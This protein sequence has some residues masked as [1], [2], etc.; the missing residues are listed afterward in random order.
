MG[1]L[2]YFYSINY[3]AFEHRLVLISYFTSAWNTIVYEITL[4]EIAFFSKVVLTFAVELI[5]KELPDEKI[6]I[7]KLNPSLATL[8]TLNPTT[9]VN[10][11]IL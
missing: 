4:I 7:L 9:F 8:F 2:S 6:P 10:M 11:L 1:S 3:F 5:I